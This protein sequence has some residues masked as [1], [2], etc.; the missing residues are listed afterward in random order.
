MALR[1]ELRPAIRTGLAL[2]AEMQVS[3]RLLQLPAAVLREEIAREAEENPFLL[4]EDMGSGGGHD[5]AALEGIAARE[6]LHAALVRQIGTQ[7]LDPAV[8]AAA[9]FLIGELRED[10]YLDTPLETLSDETGVPV[11]QLAEGLAALQRCEPAG[12]GARTLA[13]CLTLQL[14]D[15][16]VE[17]ELAQ[18]VVARL[19]DL[20]A[21]QHGA[22]AA[23]LGVGEDRIAELAELARRLRPA[24]VE[25]DAE[26]ALPRIPDLLVERDALGVPRVALNP[27]AFPRLSTMEVPGQRAGVELNA[28]LG[29]AGAFVRGLQRRG[30][31]LLRVGGHILQSQARFFAGQS[32]V[33]AP[34]GQNQAAAALGLDA[35][36]ISRA[37]R[38]KWLVFDGSVHAL[39]AFFPPAGPAGAPGL[40]AQSLQ[41]RI[42]EIVAKEDPLRPLSD[43]EIRS[44]LRGEGVD[45]ARRTVAKYRK[46]LRIASSYERRHRHQADDCPGTA[47]R[48]A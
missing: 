9:L 39:S 18:A 37:V 22:V 27:Q 36:T 4:V 43:D 34:S 44:L 11:A 10:G 25:P 32:E 2:T 13:E 7:R 12:I 28:M 26:P 8:G 19:A 38:G 47:P 17:P 5:A 24:P 29:R 33:L 46:C 48:M 30:Q 21:G 15:M 20:A 23:A 42:G 6:G 41:R 35:S 3:L 16:G 45:I 14:S 1:T 31:T 40:S